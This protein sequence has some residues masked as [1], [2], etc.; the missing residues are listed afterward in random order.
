MKCKNCGCE[1]Q[2][3]T[4]FCPVCGT[5]A[6]KVCSECG[7][8]IEEG[9]KFCLNCGKRQE[10]TNAVVESAPEAR[11]GNADRRPD[12]PEDSKAVNCVETGDL[13]LKMK[14]VGKHTDYYAGQFGSLRAGGKCRINW[15]SFFLGL[16]HAAYR[17]VSKEWIKGPG[18]PQ[19]VSALVML[20]GGGALFIS[21]NTVFMAPV[22]VVVLIAQIAGLIMNILFACRFNRLYLKHVDEKA[23]K[24]DYSPDP[25]V[26]RAI[27]VSI[28][29][30]FAISICQGIC[31]TGSAGSIIASM[32]EENGKEISGL[33][34][35]SK[36]EI[37]KFAK[38][39]KMTDADNVGIYSKEGIFFSL[40]EQGAVDMIS[41]DAAGYLLYGF[42]VGDH[43]SD[44]EGNEILTGYGYT[45]LDSS[46]GDIIF[47]IPEGKGAP[48]GDPL[49]IFRVDDDCEIQQILY[50][51]SGATEAAKEINARKAEYIFFD[52][53]S[54]YLTEEELR[55]LSDE[56]LKYAMLE[57]LARHGAVF[58]DW[59]DGTAQ[60]YFEEKSWY[61]PIISADDID[62][63][64]FNEYEMA[65]A[66]LMLSCFEARQPEQNDIMNR[67]ENES[68]RNLPEITG[69]EQ[70][71]DKNLSGV[72]ELWIDVNGGSELEIQY[73]SG[74][75]AYYAVFSGSYGDSTGYTEGYLCAYTDGTDHIWEFYD[76]TDSLLGQYAPAFRLVYDGQDTIR[77]EALDERI[78]GGNSFPGFSGTYRRT[79]EYLMP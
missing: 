27:L 48:A 39:N 75:D 6:G 24:N 66:E 78:F 38:K 46:T 42:E 7:A 59:D 45:F 68:I 37:V 5:K 9:V 34:T 51:A 49:V 63:S 29:F 21:G 23:G 73:Y 18:I 1:L 19:I 50:T 2:P 65:N 26:P 41:L 58:D 54:R 17:N 40:D 60:K 64:V 14:I 61:F 13:N 76:E 53:D 31:S 74:E 22:L 4:R 28:V 20:I 72:Y 47:G 11:T 16:F 44:P 10:E 52:S 15:A 56:E 77:V 33:L 35:A 67:L 71:A 32:G 79:E 57:I 69:N 30:G 3:E 70:T 25:S 43:L 36:K 8:E 12:I 62:D 55:E